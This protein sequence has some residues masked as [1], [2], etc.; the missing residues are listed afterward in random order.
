MTRGEKHHVDAPEMYVE[1][2]GGFLLDVLG[3]WTFSMTNVYGQTVTI[4]ACIVEGCT[5]EF[6]VGV[7]FLE[8]H[9][10]TV[11]FDR[12]EVRY[13]ERN[14]EVI[15]PFR[16]TKETTDSAVAAVRLASATNLHRRAVQ[17][18]EP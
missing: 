8:R 11:D 9:R 16:T 13:P 7:D 6:L 1:G 15:I 14:H 12:G 5:G 17:T 2:I 4:D 3:V 10:A 18:V